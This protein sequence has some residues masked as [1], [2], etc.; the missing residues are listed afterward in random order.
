MMRTLT[1]LAALAL[2]APLLALE[3]EAVREEARTAESIRGTTADLGDQVNALREDARLSKVIGDDSLNALGR[4]KEDLGALTEQELRE[5]CTKLSDAEKVALA[6]RL[7]RGR[8]ANRLQAEVLK[9]LEE[10]IKRH[11]IQREAAALE[12]LIQAQKEL[13]QETQKTEDRLAELN[14]PEKQE[15]LDT[16]AR[17]QE[18][19]KKQTE[20]EDWKKQM[21]E[22][23]KDMANDKLPQAEKKEKDLIAQMEQAAKAESPQQEKSELAALQEKLDQVKE[24]IEKLKE[25]EQNLGDIAKDNAVSPAEKQELRDMQQKAEDIKQDV[26]DNAKAEKNLDQAAK[27]MAQQQPAEAKQDVQQ[28]REALEQQAQNLEKQM[29]QQADPQQQQQNADAKLEQEAQAL[30]Q[31][32]QMEQ[33]LGQMEQAQKPEAGQAEPKP[34]SPGDQQKLD[35]MAQQAEPLKPYEHMPEAQQEMNQKDVPDARHE[36]QDAMKALAQQMMQQMQMTAEEQ[37]QMQQMDAQQMMQEM[38]KKMSKFAKKSKEQKGDKP[39]QNGG[40]GELK[41]VNGDG[42]LS[43]LPEREREAVL[44]ASQARPPAGYEDDV[45]EYYKRLAVPAK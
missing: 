23:A 10:I 42:W 14:A 19:I 13:L 1:L 29:D 9:K 44:S 7:V 34:L 20:K 41:N 24:N 27:D 8:D 4:F 40:K 16:L 12:K 33:Q 37:Q 11:K 15:K 17:E 5:I 25:M 22:I 32:A 39:G 36:V 18:E 3:A 28:A 2:P 35:Q 43:K 45:R 31:M 21:D 30:Q 6:E 26:K 38:M